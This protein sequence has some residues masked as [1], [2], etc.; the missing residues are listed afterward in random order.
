MTQR[1]QGFCSQLES[2]QQNRRIGGFNSRQA[3]IAENGAVKPARLITAGKKLKNDKNDN[4]ASLGGFDVI[5]RKGTCAKTPHQLKFKLSLKSSRKLNYS[6]PFCENFFIFAR[7]TEWGK[8]TSRTSHSI[9]NRALS[10]RKQLLIPSRHSL[11]LR[12]RWYLI[13]FDPLTFVLD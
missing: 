2:H 3:E 7:W 5:F 13:I 4:S 1:I 8:P 12:L 6:K 11:W 9:D 10:S